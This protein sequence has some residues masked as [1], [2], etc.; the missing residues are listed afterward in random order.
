MF[1]GT[2]EERTGHVVGQAIGGLMVH[3]RN[4]DNCMALQGYSRN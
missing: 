1:G 3:A 2:S 4:Y